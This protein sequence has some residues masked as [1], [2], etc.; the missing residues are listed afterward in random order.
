MGYL[1]FLKFSKHDIIFINRL[2][3]LFKVLKP[4]KLFKKFVIYMKKMRCL[5]E[6]L[7]IGL[8]K[9]KMAISTSMSRLGRNALLNSM[10]TIESQRSTSNYKR[11]SRQNETLPSSIKYPILY[12]KKSSFKWHQTHLHF[13]G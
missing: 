12:S 4:Q 1:I 2:S 9:L 10:R 6:W 5:I 8:S 11:I 3:I 7:K 13:I